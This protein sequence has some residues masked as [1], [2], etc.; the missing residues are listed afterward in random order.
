MRR[1][2]LGPWLR[3]CRRAP[4]GPRRRRCGPRRQ[5]AGGAARRRPAAAHRLSAPPRLDRVKRANGHGIPGGARYL[6]V[7]LI[8]LDSVTG[9]AAR[10][11]A[12]ESAEPIRLVYR[13]SEGCPDEASFVA[14]VRARTARARLAWA[15]ESS[16]TFTVVVEAGPPPSGRVTVDNA[17][18]AE[19]TRRVQ[20]DTCSDV[21]D[22]LALVVALATDPR[23][24]AAPAPAP[25]SS[26]RVASPPPAMPAEPEN[27][28]FSAGP[29]LVVVTVGTP[30]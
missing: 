14:R 27:R 23:G 12:Q 7:T 26:A 4:R 2:L 10:A 22:A 6:L 13:A 11:V 5:R 19:G 16:R 20:A 29:H 8:A 21:A 30:G 1:G 15:G 3:P 18:Q 17:D 28:A 25:P 24:Y 9:A